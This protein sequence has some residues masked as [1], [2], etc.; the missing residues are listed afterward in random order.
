MIS[1]GTFVSTNS[2]GAT[3]VAST[4]N[5]HFLGA[6]IGGGIGTL[7]I[8]AGT[9]TFLVLK[10][11]A[12]LDTVAFAPTVPIALQAGLNATCSGTGVCTL[13]FAVSK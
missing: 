10:S 5:S 7:T 8:K 9:G 1:A 12:N 2:A 6:A 3:L 4:A 11:T 13:F